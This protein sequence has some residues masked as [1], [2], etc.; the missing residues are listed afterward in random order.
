[1]IPQSILDFL[2][3]GKAMPFRS[4]TAF[5]FLL[6]ATL[7]GNVLIVVVL[8]LRRVFRR[9][10]GSR[11]VYIAWALVALRLLVPIALPNPLMN[12]FRPTYS[13]DAEARPVADQFRVRYHDAMRDI[14]NVLSD[15]AY[16]Y[17]SKFAE[18]LSRLTF[19]LA[20]YTSYGWLGKGYLLL[21][22]AGA[23]IVIGVFTSR[24]VRFRRRLLKDSIG[25]LED[26]QLATYQAICK[27]LK[28][29]QL[30]VVMIDPLPSPCLIGVVKP[31]IA[32]PLTLPPDA[33]KEALTHELCH[34]K[35]KDTWWAL[36]RGVCCAVHWFNPLVWIAQRFVKADC[37]LACDARVTATLT[38][39]ERL[40]Y[41][42]TLVATAKSAYAPKAGVL[43]TGMTMTGKRLKRRVN[44]ILHMQAVRKV[45]AGILAIMLALLTVLAFSTAESIS[46][47]DLFKTDQSAFSFIENEPYP[48]PDN[49]WRGSKI[50]LTPLMTAS[51]AEAQARVYIETIYLY[52]EGSAVKDYQYRANSFGKTSWEVTVYPREGGNSLYYMELRSDGSLVSLSDTASYSNGDE[53]NNI[54][55]VLPRN[56]NEVLRIYGQRMID[57]VFQGVQVDTCLIAEDYDYPTGRVLYGSFENS[58]DDSIQINYS[59][60]IAPEMKV[61]YLYDNRSENREGFPE[62]KQASLS[63]AY[64][65]DPS[66]SFA[67]ID[68]GQTDSHYAIESEPV[69][70][71]QQAFDFAIEALLKT[72]EVAPESLLQMPLCY[73][74]NDA[75]RTEATISDWVFVWYL[76]DQKEPMERYWVTVQDVAEHPSIVISAPGEGL[77]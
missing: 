71:R 40:H 50:P 1:M 76:S 73:G 21:Y 34:Y 13:V 11:L 45:A 12:Q 14:A 58:Q 69:L 5:N 20:V 37:E 56:L 16:L 7:A 44:A 26:E 28:V 23:V 64:T 59:I 25:T 46:Q 9:Q 72:D 36:V 47:S 51:E 24:H 53:K 66:L 43:S 60:Q 67:A 70:T 6:E 52:R 48:V 38:A 74:F 55:S 10:I 49:H 19:D 33:L 57:V 15:E 29:K 41:A 68:W 8:I 2:H 54:V 27:S 77:G 61:L 30:P 22:L 3:A 42:R 63:L 65:Q 31:M 75:A 4:M 35:A 39:E 18:D 17:N 62:I 32:L